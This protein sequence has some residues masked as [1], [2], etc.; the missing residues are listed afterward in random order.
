MSLTIAF[1]KSLTEEFRPR[2]IAEFVG[3][4]KPKK[5]LGKLLAQ[6]RS[7]ALL[8]LGAPGTGKSTLAMAFAAEL[9]AELT[10]IGSQECKLD[11]LQDTVSRCQRVAFNFTTGKAATFHVVLV[12]ESDCMSDAAQKFLL[13][14]LDSTEACPRT[15]WIFT[16]NSTDRLEERFLSRCL[17]LDFNSYGSGS[18]IADLLARIWA[19]KAG[20]APAPNFKRMACGN[21]RESLQ[22]L[23]VELLAV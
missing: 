4:E 6:P 20:D 19:S 13:S 22:R 16:C 21:V 8:F 9:G 3:L 1:P 15:L 10:H 23:E 17:K 14:K 5:I 7:C 2:R 12:D 11:V 18:E